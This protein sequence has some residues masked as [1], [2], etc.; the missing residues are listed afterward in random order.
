MNR[1]SGALAAVTL[2]GALGAAGPALADNPLGAYIGVGGGVSNVG[3][4]YP[5]GNGYYY[6]PGYGYGYGGGYGNDVFAWKVMAG[7]RPISILGAEIS[8][9]DFGSANGNNGY[10]GNYY[11]TGPNSHPKATSLYAV[12]YLPLPVPFLD[13]YAKAGVSRLETNLSYATCANPYG[14]TCNPVGYSFEQTNDKF[15]FGAGVQWKWQDFA[16]RAEYE[17]VSSP[18][19][20]PAAVTVGV[21]WTF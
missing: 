20:N 21:I 3:N 7:I 6:G 17:Q 1:L 9:I 18:Y 8:Y 2:A 16:F 19:G 11:Y 5:Y 14:P 4:D 12:G 10:Y 13:I 15:G